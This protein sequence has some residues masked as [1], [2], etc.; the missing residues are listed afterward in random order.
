[1]SYWVEYPDEVDTGHVE[2]GT[3]LEKRV[4][5]SWHEIAFEQRSRESKPGH[6][7][8][9][10]ENQKSSLVAHNEDRL[11]PFIQRDPIKIED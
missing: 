10:T 1:M 11:L 5:V 8:V 6:G 7:R 9:L 3:M 4:D 2:G